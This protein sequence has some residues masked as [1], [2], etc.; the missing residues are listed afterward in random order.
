MEPFGRYSRGLAKWVSRR[1][2]FDKRRYVE[3]EGLD[4]DERLL[5][6]RLSGTTFYLDGYCHREEYFKDLEQ[7]IRKDL[8]IITPTEV[9]KKRMVEDIINTDAVA[10]HACWSDEPSITVARS[11]SATYYQRAVAL[12]ERKVESPWSFLF[13]DD[14]EAARPESLVN[15][16][17]LTGTFS[18]GMRLL[19]TDHASTPVLNE[20]FGSSL[21]QRLAREWMRRSCAVS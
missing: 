17:R 10:L 4:F 18:G 14:Q 7:T 11:V 21:P 15:E 1:R 13:T 3:Q 16:S 8:R 5:A 19:Q 9:L 6:L 20:F 12:M 2:T